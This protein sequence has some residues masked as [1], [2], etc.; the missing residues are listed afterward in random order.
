MFSCQSTSS[1]VSSSIIDSRTMFVL[2]KCIIFFIIIINKCDGAA[3]P[4]YFDSNDHL[5]DKLGCGYQEVP[6]VDVAKLLETAEG[7]RKV[8]EGLLI[9][10]SATQKNVE[11]LFVASNNTVMDIGRII[12]SKLASFGM[13]NFSCEGSQGMDSKLLLNLLEKIDKEQ[14][15][16]WDE[17]VSLKQSLEMSK[18]SSSSGMSST[19]GMSSSSSGMFSTGSNITEL[20]WSTILHLQKDLRNLQVKVSTLPDRHTKTIAE[21]CV[22]SPDMPKDCSEIARQGEI[23]SGVFKIYPY[24]CGRVNESVL[25]WCDLEGPNNGWTVVLSRKP[26]PKQVDFDRNW[27]D[28]KN[29]FGDPQ[30]E[31]WLGNDALYSIASS[32]RQILRIDMVDWDGAKKYVEY[33]SL[34]VECE[35]RNY[36]IHLG[37]YSGDGGDSLAYHNHMS[38]STSDRDNDLHDDNCAKLFAGG[39]WYN[40]CHKASPTATLLEKQRSTKGINWGTWYSDRTTLREIYFKIREYPCQ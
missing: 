17:I 9:K 26:V 16:L 40:K 30:T 34:V 7:N 18:T 27:S 11:S 10:T 1:L 19:E 24:R 13:L 5:D 20:L 6:K 38:F 36:R 39:F 25:V 22:R 31:H 23:G 12:D 21:K 14:K 33:D 15:R 28:Y 8:L 32:A 2:C 37:G 35:A 3:G 4:P 29:G